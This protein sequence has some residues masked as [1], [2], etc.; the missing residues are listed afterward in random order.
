MTATAAALLNA[1]RTSEAE[2]AEQFVLGAIL[3]DKDA[4]PKAAEILTEDD[5]DRSAHRKILA[6]MVDL[7]EANEEI[8]NI[9]L[10]E[11]LRA[12]GDLEAV[13]GE[14]RLDGRVRAAVVDQRAEALPGHGAAP[15][16]QRE[17]HQH[18]GQNGD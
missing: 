9:T 7:S 8:D 1:A 18:Q 16:R 3:L 17:R 10:A 2:Q 12:R 11:R 13:G 14:P 5:F 15:G 4:L 6:A